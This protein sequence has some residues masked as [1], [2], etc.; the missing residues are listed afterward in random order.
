MFAP[1]SQYSFSDVEAIAI[2]DAAAAVERAAYYLIK[3]IVLDDN[4]RSRSL[5]SRHETPV[6]NTLEE[7]KAQWSDHHFLFWL[8]SSPGSLPAGQRTA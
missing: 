7:C 1:F 6:M 3:G 4:R 8:G 5:P 2:A